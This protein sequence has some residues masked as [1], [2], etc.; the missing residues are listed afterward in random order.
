LQ[1]VFVRQGGI[2]VGVGRRHDA[3]VNQSDADFLPVQ[4]FLRQ[5]LEEGNRRAAAGNRQHCAAFVIQRVLQRGGDC[6]C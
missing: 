6:V 5:G 3:L 1:Q 2:A 4:I